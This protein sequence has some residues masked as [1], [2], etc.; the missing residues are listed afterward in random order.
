MADD[1]EKESSRRG[2]VHNLAHQTAKSVVNIGTAA[3]EG[4]LIATVGETVKAPFRI[5]GALFSA[6][7]EDDD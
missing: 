4:S 2:Y 3:A 1:N 7:R 5:V 6:N